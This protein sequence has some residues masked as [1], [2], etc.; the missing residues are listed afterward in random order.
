MLL[1]EKG[2]LRIIFG[3][4]TLAR[5]VNNCE[6]LHRM[7]KTKTKKGNTCITVNKKTDINYVFGRT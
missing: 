3:G 1:A 7:S 4:G 5:I 2:D 6:I